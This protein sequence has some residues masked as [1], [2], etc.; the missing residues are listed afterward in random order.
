MMSFSCERR[1]KKSLNAIVGIGHDV[2]SIKLA[3]GKSESNS[4]RN[5]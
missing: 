2:E 4:I 5:K 1:I 3:W